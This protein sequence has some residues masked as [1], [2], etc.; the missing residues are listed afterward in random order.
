MGRAKRVAGSVGNPSRFIFLELFAFFLLL[1]SKTYKES[2][3]KRLNSPYFF[4][5][6][7]N[8]CLNHHCENVLNLDHKNVSGR[9]KQRK[10]K[11]QS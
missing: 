1:C 9:Q 4:V 8:L 3:R 6:E 7:Q 5:D 10:E 11:K 2:I